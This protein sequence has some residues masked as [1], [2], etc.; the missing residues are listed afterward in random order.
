MRE[1]IELRE[2]DGERLKMTTEDIWFIDFIL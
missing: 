1:S 2:N